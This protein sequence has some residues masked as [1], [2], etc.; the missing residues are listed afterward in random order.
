VSFHRA[1]KHAL[2]VKYGGG[3]VTVLP[4]QPDGRLGSASHVT[5]RQGTVGPI[6]PSNAPPGSFAIS[7]HD[8][9]HAHMIEADT[10]G[11]FVLAAD[12]GLDQILVWRFDA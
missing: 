3:S 10:S 12:L 11:R 1:G 5:R 6:R 7:G 2:V 9:P 4:M 8:R